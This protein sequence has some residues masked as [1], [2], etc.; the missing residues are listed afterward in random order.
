MQKQSGARFNILGAPMASSLFRYKGGAI[1]NVVA[2]TYTVL[3]YA[4]GL[5]L[6]TSSS[7][8]INALG[9]LLLA[10]AL[11]YSAYFLHE[12]AHGTVFK[13]NAANQRGGTAM[14]WINGSCYAPFTDLRRKH[15]RHHIDR[16][17]VITFDYRQFL[18]ASAR[19]LRGTVVALEWAYLPA[20]EFLMRAYV[21]L[22]PFIEPERAAARKRILGVFTVRVLFFALLGWFSL[23][24]LLLY[25]LA[26]V[27]FITALR[28]ADA[29]QHTYDAFAILS[30]GGIPDDKLRDHE[31]EQHNT[32]SNLV[33]VRFPWM[34]LLLL[35]FS[36]HNAHHEKPTAPWHQLPAL[37]RQLYADEHA[38]VIPMASLLRGF[39][40]DRVRRVLSDDYGVVTTGPDKA[41]RFYG[42]VG[43]SFLTAV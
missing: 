14:S 40:R 30:T 2:L 22:L 17:D 20:V 5:A 26:Y 28:F 18:L 37:H 29:Y 16:A 34:N 11:I 31:Y 1:P 3:G 6:I 15:M 23:K 8:W 12:F 21:M 43:V 13:T 41:E 27:L 7:W 24:A 32:Y 4:G 36:Y 39:H 19:W 25:F 10:H 33:T 38:Q 9:V 42:A 35:N